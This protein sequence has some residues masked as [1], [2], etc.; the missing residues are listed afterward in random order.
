MRQLN[1]VFQIDFLQLMPEVAV[2]QVAAVVQAADGV[3]WRRERTRRFRKTCDT[4][5]RFGPL[6]LVRF[7]ERAKTPVHLLCAGSFRC[8]FRKNGLQSQ[9]ANIAHTEVRKLAQMPQVHLLRALP[10][11]LANSLDLVSVV[12]LYL[13]GSSACT[14]MNVIVVVVQQGS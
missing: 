2:R 9:S 1:L 10:L 3:G 12:R 14:G 4:E 7:A 13:C 5:K 6:L 8:L 11:P